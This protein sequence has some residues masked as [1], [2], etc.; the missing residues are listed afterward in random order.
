MRTDWAGASMRIDEIQPDYQATVGSMARVRDHTTMR[1]DPAKAAQAIL[2]IAL[3]N[4][5][6]LRLLLGSD[7]VFFA[8]AIAA[9]RAADDAHWKPLSV[10][11]DFAGSVP[12]AE[13][14]IAKTIL[15]GGRA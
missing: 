8:G 10:S 12:F 1:S 4:Q 13:T 11:T 7:A 6:P 9:T 5:P 2:R 15:D 3:E 14:A